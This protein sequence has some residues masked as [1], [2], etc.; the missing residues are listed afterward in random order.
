MPDYFSF[1]SLPITRYLFIPIITVIIGTWA[2]YSSQNDKYDL[3]KR[4]LFYWS[5]DII[6]SG[7]IVV[8]VDFANNCSASG[9]TVPVTI[10]LKFIGCLFVCL[11]GLIVVGFIIRKFGW[12][13]P[14]PAIVR[15]HL[16]KGIIIPNV[17][18]VSVLWII[19]KIMQS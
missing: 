11:S 16:W 3:A 19:F 15:L 4:D 6:V 8:F 17:I 9:T 14:I 12:E 7:F 1:I 2:R 18:A 5:H 13:K 10:I